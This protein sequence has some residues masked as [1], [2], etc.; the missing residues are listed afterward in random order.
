[1]RSELL[2]TTVQGYIDETTESI[3]LFEGAFLQMIGRGQGSV[4]WAGASGTIEWTNFPPRRPDGIYLPDITGIIRLDSSERPIM[5]RMQ[6][7]SLRPDGEGRRLF[8]GPVRWYTDDPDLLHLNDRWGYEEGQLDLGTLRFR[9]RA[10]ILHPEPLAVHQ[11]DS[12][13]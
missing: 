7:I 13:P 9:T 10:Y 6:G 11:V 12:Q 2:Y 3:E 4:D 5:Y 1:M 8:A